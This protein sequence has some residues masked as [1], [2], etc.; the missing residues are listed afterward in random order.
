MIAPPCTNP[1]P[2]GAGAHCDAPALPE[3]KI[4]L[5]LHTDNTAQSQP[6]DTIAAGAEPKRAS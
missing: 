6:G 3:L 1:A 4:S 2:I 5:R